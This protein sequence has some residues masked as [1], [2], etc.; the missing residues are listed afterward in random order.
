MQELLDLVNGLRAGEM[1]TK[2]FIGN[3]GQWFNDI[4]VGGPVTS[5]LDS[6]WFP[7]A[8]LLV[9]A[10]FLFYGRKW[11]GLIKFLS[12]GAIGF[13]AGLVV[14]PMLEGMLPFLVGKAWI[15]GALCALIL[16]VLNKLVFGLLYFGGPAAAAFAVCYLPN[17]IPVENL[18]TVG[19]IP[20]CAGVAAVAA[21]IMLA[22]RKDFER[23]ATAIGGAT[24]INMG[25][26]KLYDYLTLIPE[27]Y[28]KYATYV[29]VGVV[30]LLAVLGYVYQYRRRRRY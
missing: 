8:A 19:N 24:L 27:A 11:I 17:I 29:D 15:T 18:P 21:L 30:A 7:F 26:R 6:S 2:E 16:A 3:L 1:T 12:F 10:I 22:I 28:S 13:I 4:G 9:G 14:S 20:M 23:I 5:C 25:V